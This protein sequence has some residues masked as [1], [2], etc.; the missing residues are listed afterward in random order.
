[1]K[2]TNISKLI[3]VL[4]CLATV[5]TLFSACSGKKEKNPEKTEE[6]YAPEW[7]ISPSIEAQAIDPIVRATFNENTNHYDI[8][9]DA[10]FRIMQNSKYGIIDFNGKT[11][12]EPQFDELYAIRG[13]KDYMGITTDSDGDKE[14]TYI[15]GGSFETETA[16]K[17]YN[18]EK[19][20]YYWNT[21]SSEVVFVKTEA[22]DSK[23]QDGKPSLP[24]VVKGVNR[25]G[26]AY[27]ADGTYG[28]YSNS[29]NVT[30]MIYSGA[31]CFADS[32]AAFLS[33][34]KWGYIDSNGRTVI[35][36][37]YDAVWNYSAL[38]GSDTPYESYNGFITLCKDKKFGVM[39]DD[40]SVLIPFIFD[41]ATPVV[42]GMA[43]VKS[44][45]KWGVLL[46]DK[47]SVTREPVSEDTTKETET[48]EKTDKTEKTTDT[49]T[50]GE[51]TTE[52]K[53]YP[54]GLYVLDDYLTLRTDPEYA[55][56]NI[57]LTVDEGEEVRVDGVEGNWGH[58]TYDGEEGWINLDYAEKVEEE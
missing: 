42:N 30:G 21:G 1:M 2:R 16:Y 25:T 7:V 15:T 55:D 19:Y 51:T 33:N 54:A 52:A 13:T 38:G 58:I 53:S 22:G 18:T 50:E 3:A 43:F 44:G 48:T 10:Y 31:G 27:K 37:E 47:N 20:E 26:N 17:K 41:G 9:Y 28:L 57:I 6:E 23:Q 45:G 40:G 12:V 39:K 11:V 32:K 56:D 24:E 46:V 8:T 4:L 36:F 35:P 29:T 5:L 14:Q 49:S 34:G